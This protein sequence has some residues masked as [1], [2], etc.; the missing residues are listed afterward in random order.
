MIAHFAT[1]NFDLLLFL[2][3]DDRH[4]CFLPVLLCFTQQQH[5][6]AEKSSDQGRAGQGRAGQGRAGQGRVFKK[7]LLDFFSCFSSKTFHLVQLCA[8][9]ILSIRVF[10]Y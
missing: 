9:V 3:G 10:W 1:R 2:F 7:I 8:C 6:N 4:F 5:R